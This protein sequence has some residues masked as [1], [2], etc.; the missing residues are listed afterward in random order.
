M[1]STL[2][3]QRLRNIA[4]DGP[5]PRMV[6]ARVL[7]A[8]SHKPRTRLPRLALAPVAALILVALLAYFAPAADVS[9][10]SA[11]G[12][13]D[14]LREAGLVG[15]AD[16]V[17]FVG[18]V[19]TSS[20]YRIELVGA[21]ADASRTVLLLRSQPATSPSN[22][23]LQIT[24]QFGRSYQFR[25]GYTNGLTREA[26]YQFE[27][28]A[29]PDANL[30]ARIT[31]HMSSVGNGN[32]P[33]ERVPGSWTFSAVVGV[34]QPRPLP[35]P[36]GA[37]L[38]PAHFKF[39]S[40]AYTPASVAID[41]DIAGVNLSDV[42]VVLPD[43]GKGTPILDVQLFGPAGDA[44]TGSYDLFGP[45]TLTRSGDGVHVHFIGYHFGKGEYRLVVRYG[46]DTFERVLEIP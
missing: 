1:T 5:D 43:G 45:G 37:T 22:D 9:L 33:Y 28:L 36:D 40:V 32:P 34:D 13:G 10:A 7:A 31:F 20:G 29:W 3:E 35:L 44:V 19:A 14:L 17:T 39:N 11:P 27:P 24:D 41:M 23:E 42:N 38:G 46:H 15:A 2:L 21:Y 4:S 18:A 30:G 8:S 12:F 16:R 6:S 25:N 26:V